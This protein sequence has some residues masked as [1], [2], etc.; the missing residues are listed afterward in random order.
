M[1][2]SANKRYPLFFFLILTI[3]NIAVWLWKGYFDYRPFTSE[4]ALYAAPADGAP[5]RQF[6]TDFPAADEQAATHFLDSL[7]KGEDTSRLAQINI[8][9]N[10]LQRQF[11]NRLGRPEINEQLHS[12]WEMYNYF[13]A[14][15]SRK[16]WCGH[17]ALV[18]NYFCLARGIDSRMIE[19]FKP[20]D[21]HVVNECF[22]PT[23]NKWVLV[24]ITYNQLQV[25]E[26]TAAPLNLAE[27]RRLAGKNI[28]LRVQQ[29]DSFRTLRPD[30]GYYKNYY[31]ITC[32]AYYYITVSREK[33]YKSSEKLKR[34]LLP[35]SWYK[36]LAEENKPNWLFYV[37]Q[38]LLIGWIFSLVYMI[39]EWR[40]K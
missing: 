25:S 32:P 20:G 29:A 34:Y 38:V 31:S 37:K 16:L 23:Y 10:Y 18:F 27:F 28:S 3:L 9:G 19:L 4:R 35:V 24:D 17:L 13:M 15:S 5:W 26:G 14:D 21:H 1:N 39:R 33:V 2:R 11:S 22:I 40:R 7:L 6:L 8:I 36:I 30:T 12:P